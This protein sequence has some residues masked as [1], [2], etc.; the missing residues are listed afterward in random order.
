MRR[1]IKRKKMASMDGCGAMFVLLWRKW[2]M[3]EVETLGAFI[4]LNTSF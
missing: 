1:K 4:L 2:A 3:L